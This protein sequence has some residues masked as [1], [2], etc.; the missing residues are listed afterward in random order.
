ML[1]LLLLLLV[2]H[3]FLFASPPPT[4][5][6]GS[7]HLPPYF[8]P[9]RDVISWWHHLC[10]LIHNYYWHNLIFESRFSALEKIKLFFIPCLPRSETVILLIASI[11]SSCNIWCHLDHIFFKRCQSYIT[12]LK[13]KLSSMQH[14]VLHMWLFFHN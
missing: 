13:D 10:S 11:V 5:S 9:Q 1:S 4:I 3:T 12:N 14:G 2:R 8:Q 7:F 6:R